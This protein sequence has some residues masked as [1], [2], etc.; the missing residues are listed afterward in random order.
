MEFNDLLQPS[1]RLFS[2]S[3]RENSKRFIR[4]IHKNMRGG[5]VY[6]NLVFNLEMTRKQGVFISGGSGSG[7]SNLA[8]IL[9]D[10]L[11]E[12]NLIPVIFDPSQIWSRLYNRAEIVKV[13]DPFH[14]DILLEAPVIYDISLLYLDHQLG[15]FTEITK[16]YVETQIQL[17]QSKRPPYIFI[18]EEAQMII[19]RGKLHTTSALELMRL[20]TVGRNYN[21]R[22]MVITPRPADIDTTAI[23]LCG[24]HY[25]GMATEENDL[26]KIRNWVGRENIRY[27]PRLEVGEFLYHA[28]GNI[29]RIRVPRLE[30]WREKRRGETK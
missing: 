10:I 7:K 18:V 28:K 14:L 12:N 8:M 13:T 21:M 11:L 20:F 25:F 22:Y 27:L 2:D 5:G 9:A 30:E 17:D 4:E 29:S 1:D 16:S 24:Q 3:K 23:S 6:L 19:P 26:R 15:T